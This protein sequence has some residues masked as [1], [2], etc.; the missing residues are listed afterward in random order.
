MTSRTIPLAFAL[1]FVAFFC[2]DIWPAPRRRVQGAGGCRVPP[3]CRLAPRRG[4]TGGPA[5]RSEEPGAAVL[6]TVRP[7]GPGSWARL[8]VVRGVQLGPWAAWFGGR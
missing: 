5:A 7:L 3:G 8:G 4:H 1:L 6:A 2:E